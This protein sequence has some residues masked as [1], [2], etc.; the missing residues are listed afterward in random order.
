MAEVILSIKETVILKKKQIYNLHYM[1][2]LIRSKHSQNN[3]CGLKYLHKFVEIHY[4]NTIVK[5]VDK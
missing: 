4:C 1:H 3:L 2:D 5:H